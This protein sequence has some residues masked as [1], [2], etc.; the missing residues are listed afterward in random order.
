[1][2]GRAGKVLAARR[3]PRWCG[4]GEGPRAACAEAD[5]RVC[6]AFLALRSFPPRRRPA[7]ARAASR[8][9]A[10][11]GAR[12]RAL[13]CCCRCCRPRGRPRP[14]R[15]PA[16]AQ[17]GRWTRPCLAEGGLLLGRLPARPA[18]RWDPAAR[19]RGT[20]LRSEEGPGLSPS[21]PA[22]PCVPL[23]LGEAAQAPARG[24]AV[25]FRDPRAVTASRTEDRKPG[26][27]VAAGSPGGRHSR[28]LQGHAGVQAGWLVVRCLSPSAPLLGRAGSRPGSRPP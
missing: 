5:G 22:S 1:M 2:S 17:W 11:S 26:G 28:I 10:R 3:R 12:R 13:F 25:S 16:R 8:A 7:V 27:V 24:R 4:R 15:T 21:E 23:R 14:P 18:L 19:P 6:G 9:R 20:L